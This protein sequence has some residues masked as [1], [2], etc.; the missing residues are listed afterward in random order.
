MRRSDS[1]AIAR[2]ITNDL[3]LGR[4][5][6]SKDGIKLAVIIMGLFASQTSIRTDVI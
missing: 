5:V 1:Q 6:F 2:L 4:S 3:R